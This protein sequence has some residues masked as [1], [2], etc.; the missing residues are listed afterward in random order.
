MTDR[1]GRRTRETKSAG[2][3]EA[4]SKKLPEFNCRGGKKPKPAVTFK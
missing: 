3:W 1:E 4:P 2:N